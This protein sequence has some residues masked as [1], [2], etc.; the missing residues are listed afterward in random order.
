[1]KTLLNVSGFIFQFEIRKNI[2]IFKIFGG[3]NGI[4]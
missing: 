4:K 1:M 2:K 3:K